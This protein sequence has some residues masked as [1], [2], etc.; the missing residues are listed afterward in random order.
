MMSN[1][2]PVLTR[3]DF[4]KVGGAL[5]VSASLPSTAKAA[6][7][8][9]AGYTLDATKLVSWLELHADGSIIARTGKT[10]TGTAS[11]AFYAQ[12]VAE[13]LDVDPKKVSIIGGHT[14]ETPDGGYSAGF[15][16]GVNN[17]KKVAAYTRQALLGLAAERLGVP[18]AGLTVAGGVV[19]GGGK[20]VS[21]T[22]LVKGQQLNLT[23]PV[24]GRLARIDPKDPI[25]ITDLAGIT[26]TGNPPMKPMDKYTVVG[27]S[28]PRSSIADIAM[29]RAVYS[30]DVKV[31]GMLHARMVRPASLGSTLVSAGK[32]DKARF[33]TAEVVVQKNLVAVVSP[34]EWEAV[35][36]ARAVAAATQWT[37][38]TGLPGSGNVTATLR[39]AKWE[40]VG[41]RGDPAKADAGLTKAARTI[42]ASYEQPYVRHAPMGAFVATADVKADGTVTIWS[43]SSQPQGA[44]AHIAHI[45]SVPVEKVV[46][47]WA[48]GPGQYGRTTYG[49]DGAMADA[50]ILSKL[51]GKP[52]RVQWTIS[53][54]LA[55]SSTSPAWVADVK[56]GLDDKGNMVAFKS[57]WYSPHE[58]DAR[59]IGA[60]LAGAPEI[61]PKTK[62]FFPAISTVWPYDKVPAVVESAYGIANL[63]N[64]SANGGLRGNIMRTPWQRQQNFALEAA[65]E[66]AAAAAKAD[67]I[68][69]RIRHTSDARLIE[70]LNETAQAAGWKSRPS[71]SPQ[72]SASGSA[73]V[74]GRG[75]G[76]VIRSG[77]Q[78]VGIAEVE[79]VPAT[80]V[81][82][83]LSFT[84]GVD[85][86]KVM[87]PRHLK[88]NIEGGTVMGLGEA[89][90][91]EVT[92]D[93]SKVTSTDWTKYKIPAMG[94]VPEVK[95][96]FTSRNGRGIN[97]GGEAAN[98]VSANAVAAAFF[99]ATGV[100]PRRVPLTP[101]YVKSI[102][103][104]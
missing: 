73:P 19:S 30:G 96:V 3:R 32:L 9:D 50:A 46:I 20:S 23:I 26:V 71:P 28:H 2:I 7:G 85:V 66:E 38:W 53:E 1:P 45:M 61:S 76:V 54:D 51:V 10:E 31:P 43:Q 63:A 24:T 99:D 22:D 40:D 16:G 79:V 87:N 49:G 64:D 65:V 35:S 6:A 86:G 100:Q 47:R 94:D 81:V 17:L 37:A 58:N 91:E 77:A 104:A 72:A 42:N 74:R 13:E 93:A 80:G 12:A 78:W 84:T 68:E 57:D 59:M 102:L 29:G 27:E 48:Q 82:K 36:G 8:A 44:R 5:V 83:V 90:F 69:Y 56:V 62:P 4:V 25:G 18:A 97:G 92:F 41:R 55:W 14:D 89:L 95:T 33:P 52:V 103:K 34:N 98:T 15:L 67:P 70:I 11:T 75:V 88:S 101:T 39:S 21:Y 60:V